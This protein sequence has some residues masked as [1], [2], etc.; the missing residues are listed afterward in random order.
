MPAENCA[1]HNDHSRTLERQIEVNAD[2]ERRLS[3]VES[4][5]DVSDEKFKQVFEKLDEIIAILKV[6]QSRLPNMFWGVGGSVA[7]GLIVWLVLEFLKR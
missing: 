6:N 2:F 7:G 1:N 5:L 4:R 3:K